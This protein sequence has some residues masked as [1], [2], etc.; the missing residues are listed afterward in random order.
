MNSNISWVLQRVGDIQT[1]NRPRPVPKPNE[2]E[3]AVKATGICGSD[4]IKLYFI[5]AI[6][7]FLPRCCIKIQ[8]ISEQSSLLGSWLHW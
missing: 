5:F 4:G 6:L 1:E 8:I 3:I 7:T 2:V